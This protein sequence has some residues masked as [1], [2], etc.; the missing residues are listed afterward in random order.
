[1]SYGNRQQSRPDPYNRNTSHSKTKGYHWE[2]HRCNHCQR[3]T[4]WVGAGTANPNRIQCL[5]C[6]S[7]MDA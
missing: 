3:V 6:A 2:D 7:E 1:M 4:A 5:D